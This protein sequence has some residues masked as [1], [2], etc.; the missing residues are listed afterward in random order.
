MLL[1]LDNRNDKHYVGE[2]L[3]DLLANSD[4]VR[5][6]L[7]ARRAVINGKLDTVSIGRDYTDEELARELRQ[8]AQYVLQNRYGWTLFTSKD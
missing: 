2:T 4:A 8:R 7:Q 5:F 1:L 6:D 3:A